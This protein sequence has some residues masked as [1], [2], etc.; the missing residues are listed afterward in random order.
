MSLIFTFKNNFFF[1]LVFSKF[2]IIQL[3]LE[4]KKLSR[5]CMLSKEFRR[6]NSAQII[7]SLTIVFS[8]KLPEFHCLKTTKHGNAILW[9]Y[10]NIDKVQ[11]AIELVATLS[12]SLTYIFKIQNKTLWIKCSFVKYFNAILYYCYYYYYRPTVFFLN[13]IMN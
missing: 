2:I 7:T 8:D 1:I 4:Q 9:T 11:C 13:Q 10:L 6:S 3:D 12:I 5:T